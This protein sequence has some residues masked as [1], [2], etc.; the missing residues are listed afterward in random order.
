MILTRRGH[1]DIFLIFLPASDIVKKKKIRSS[2]VT[3][4]VGG[5]ETCAG[6]DPIK[7]SETRGIN[8]LVACDNGRHV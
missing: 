3:Y 5:L 2:R 1:S 4:G 8:C 7:L 6:A